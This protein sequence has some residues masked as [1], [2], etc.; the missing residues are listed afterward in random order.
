M[1]TYNTKIRCVGV[2]HPPPTVQWKKLSGELSSRISNSSSDQT[3]QR[4]V[5]R[6]IVELKVT[7]AHR[8]DTGVYEC[9]VNSQQRNITDN[10]SLTVQCM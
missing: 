5:T 2:G 8:E 7:G 10:V 6:V 1:E 4:N 9:T 3:N